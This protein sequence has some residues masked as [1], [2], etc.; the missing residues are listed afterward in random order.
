MN[1]DDVEDIITN[2]DGIV[3]IDEAYIDFSEKPSFLKLINTYPNLILMHT[4]SKAFGLAA[5]RVGMAFS[6]PEIIR[7]FNKLKPPYNISTINQKAALN[8][9]NNMEGVKN[10]VLRI[11]RERDKLSMILQKMK[12]VETVYPSD[13]NFL[14]VK[15]KNADYIYNTLINNNIITRNRSSVVDN[16]LRITVG[17]RSE[18]DILIDAFY[19]LDHST[20][21]SQQ[22]E[23]N[24][25]DI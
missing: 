11:R 8:K 25:N 7:Y 10:Q 22:K 12:V 15:V 21:G 16:C 23:A 14:L 20:L 3:V 9:L 24:L 4:F 13:A 19:E 2:F 1:F 17:K 5:A 18:N 6:S